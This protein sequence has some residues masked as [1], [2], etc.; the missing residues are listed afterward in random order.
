MLSDLFFLSHVKAHA[1]HNSAAVSAS[2]TKEKADLQKEAFNIQQ[3]YLQLNTITYEQQAAKV[4]ILKSKLEDIRE[5]YKQRIKT[6]H[7]TIDKWTDNPSELPF[8]SEMEEIMI[9]CSEEMIKFSCVLISECVEALSNNDRSPPCDFSVLAF[10]SLAKGEATPYSDLEYLFLIGEKTTDTEEYFQHLAMTSYFLIGN[11]G[12][13]TLDYMDVAEVVQDKWFVDCS[14]SG[15]KIDGLQE[16]AGNIPTGNGRVG[17]TNRFIVTPEELKSRYAYVLNN[18]VKELAKEGDLTAM[19]RFT[20]EIYSTGASAENMH[21]DFQEFVRGCSRSQDRVEVNIEML[22]A[23]TEKFNFIPDEKVHDQGFIVNVKKDLY[24]FPSILLLDLSIV[25]NCWGESS[26]KTVDEL[27][28]LGRISSSLHRALKYLL[29]CACYV[30]LSAYLYHDSHHN[31]VSVAPKYVTVELAQLGTHRQWFTPN[32][33]F[34]RLCETVMPL[35][36][37]LSEKLESNA[38]LDLTTFQVEHHWVYSFLSFHSSG[39]FMDALQT[40]M[41]NEPDA[42]AAVL[43]RLPGHLDKLLILSTVEDTL[44]KCSKLNESLCFA[45]Y[46]NSEYGGDLSKLRLAKSYTSV[47]KYEKALKIL[48]ALEEHVKNTAEIHH[49]LARTNLYRYEKAELPVKTALQCN[50]NQEIKC[51]HRWVSNFLSLHSSGQ[52][53]D[54]LQVLTKYVPD[55]LTPDAVLAQLPEHFD[56]LH[57]LSTVKDTLTKCSKLNA[58]IHHE[59]VRTNLHLH[60]YEKAELHAKIALQ[61][62]Y[63]QEIKWNHTDKPNLIDC[64]DEQRLE[65]I[66]LGSPNILRSLLQFAQLYASTR[67]FELRQLYINKANEMLSSVYGDQALIYRLTDLWSIMAA[68]DDPGQNYSETEKMYWRALELYREMFGENTDH[69]NIAMAMRNL[70]STYLDRH[71]KCTTPGDF[72]EQAL[73]YSEQ[74]LDMFRRIHGEKSVHTDIIGAMHNLGQIHFKLEAGDN[75]RKAEQCFKEALSLLRRHHGENADHRDI[76]HTLHKQGR[77]YREK[78]QYDEANSTLMEAL[79]KYMKL[80]NN[81]AHLDIANVWWELGM[82]H[83]HNL[84]YHDAKDSLG[85]ALAMYRRIFGEESCHIDICSAMENI[86]YCNVRCGEIDTAIN[87]ASNA[88]ANYRKLYKAQK[89]RLEFVRMLTLIA[90]CYLLHW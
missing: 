71:M 21:K 72:L 82:N 9:N 56:K 5:K 14:K 10:G 58:E 84:R 90:D 33:L 61:H 39:R 31:K 17:T 66:H 13:T 43:A 51:H 38:K 30:R 41:K 37:L 27:K 36:H 60:N 20:R 2:D 45:T 89:H 16:K 22:K 73:G 55:A 42:A 25:Y 46:I 49:E 32:K 18:P 70:G 85:K 26:W 69:V 86:S 1:L 67:R 63:N 88:L 68:S 47:G 54:A 4:D 40:L 78:R 11:L 50:Y 76:A 29:A 53:M 35:K 65:L 15:F 79:E 80:Y 64:S 3:R 24:R 75:N 6:Q 34:M 23:D 81:T 8:I 77:F 74:A 87:Y 44:T 19:L 62:N 59:L 48:Q 12:E 28:K 57:I 7:Q 83:Y 52:F